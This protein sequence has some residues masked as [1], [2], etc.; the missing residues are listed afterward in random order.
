[1]F[2]MWAVPAFESWHLREECAL[3]SKYHPAHQGS[4]AAV[5]LHVYGADRGINT[6]LTPRHT[7]D[8]VGERERAFGELVGIWNEV[9]AEEVL[10]ERSR[11]LE[12]EAGKLWVG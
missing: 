11:A 4:T 5:H 12:D 2:R 8:Q 10:G 3:T 7:D 1:M 6:H 9:W